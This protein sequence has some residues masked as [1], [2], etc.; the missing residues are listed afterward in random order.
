MAIKNVHRKIRVGFD[1]DGVLYYNPVKVLR[2]LIYF[3]KR[4]IFKIE[5]TKFYIPKNGK[6]KC[7]I[8]FLHKSSIMPNFGFNSFLDLVNNPQYEVY[9]ITARLSF[10]KGNIETLL[11]KYNLKNVKKIIQ[12]TTPYI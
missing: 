3:V 5:Q 8:T 4:Y 6:L 11:S 2:P 12:N 9:I 1:F 10:M 7:V